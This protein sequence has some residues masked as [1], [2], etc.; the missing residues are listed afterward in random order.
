MFVPDSE[1]E[2]N[3]L[4]QG[5]VLRDIY[6][7]GAINLKNVN[8]ESNVLTGPTMSLNYRST[9]GTGAGIV[10]SHSCE[11]DPENSDKVTSIL[12][13]P[14]RDVNSATRPDKIEQLKNSN[15]IPEEGNAPPSFLKYFYLDPLP[16]ISFQS[17]CI[18]DFSKIFSLHKSSMEFLRERKVAQ[19]RPEMAGALT[20]KLALFFYR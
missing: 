16:T 2:T 8:A 6:L 1:I 7:F 5:D 13:A 10:L 14:L 9:A 4:R 20:R 12:L 19:M 3:A 18:V 17:G 11:L 15:V